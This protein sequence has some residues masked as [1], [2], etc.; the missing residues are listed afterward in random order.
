MEEQRCILCEANF[1]SSA[2]VGEKCVVC[3]A[4]YPNAK[5]KEG[6]KVKSK[7]KAKT[8]SEETVKEIIYDILE[9][10]NLKRVVCDKCNKKFFR[11]SPAQKVCVNCRE[12]K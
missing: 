3:N 11:N 7:N 10:A 2:M 5:T 6:I 9:E 1:R 8:L 4:A 12:V